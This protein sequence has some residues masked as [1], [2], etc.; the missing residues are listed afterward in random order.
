VT[1]EIATGKPVALADL[2][3]AAI[4]AIIPW[5]IDF[6]PQMKDALAASV[7]TWTISN[8]VPQAIGSAHLMNNP[9]AQND[10]VSIDVVLAKGTWSLFA[11]LAKAVTG[12]IATATLGGASLTSLGGSANTFDGYAAATTYN[13]LFSS[14]GIVIPTTGK[15]RL[16]F[17]MATRNVS[18]TT[19]WAL[20]LATLAFVR[21]A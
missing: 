8:N 1:V 7:G 13:N 10:S 9:S 3:Q 16:T 18:N 15:Y 6:V 14:T 12:A 19:G 4:D 5:R 21:T 17:T 11:Y 2:T 20:F